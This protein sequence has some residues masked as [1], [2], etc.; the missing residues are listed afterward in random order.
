[1]FTCRQVLPNQKP[2]GFLHKIKKLKI[3]AMFTI[4]QRK[5]LTTDIVL[6][7]VFAPRIAAGILPGQYV[8]V[9]PSEKTS[10]VF[11]P[12]TGTNIENGS[13]SLLVHVVDH[14]TGQLANNNEIN[15]LANLKGP[16]GKPSELTE[17]NDKELQSSG[18]LFV[19]GGIASA[20]ALAQI[21][22]LHQLGCKV[23][24][25]LA[26]QTRN[27]FLF[28]DQ[29][30]KIC[31]NVFLATE[32]GSVGFHGSATQ[33]LG[34]LFEKQVDSYDLVTIFGTLKMMKSVSD[35][36]LSYGV[37]ATANF[38]LQLTDSFKNEP[39]AFRLNVNGEIKDVA[40]DGPEFNAH[41][42]DF[43]HAISRANISLNVT[44][45]IAEAVSGNSKVHEIG[46][47]YAGNVLP[48]QA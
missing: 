38:G 14:S 9:L 4:I 45:N 41:V 33:L 28:R 29:F 48:K 24:V 2:A 44:E 13:I 42:V 22:W 46:K 20:T 25:I 12:V 19:V 39:S 17:C 10:S 3:A 18:M 16:L 23:D 32:D 7:E 8:S 1:V 26:A 21:K 15:I 6:I 5:R 40:T 47:L 35:L 43:E 27:D 37:P 11:L 31:R 34:L 30:E 36:T